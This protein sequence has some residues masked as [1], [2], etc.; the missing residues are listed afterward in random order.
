MKLKDKENKMPK[1]LMIAPYK[2]CLE[3]KQNCEQVDEELQNCFFY[4]RHN[5]NFDDIFNEEFKD[6][7]KFQI[8]WFLD[9]EKCDIAL[10][11]SKDLSKLVEE[12][13]TEIKNSL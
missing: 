7:L 8:L 12:I 4:N 10:N 9:N 2:I 11:K 13:I 5:K 1:K 6:E 3:C